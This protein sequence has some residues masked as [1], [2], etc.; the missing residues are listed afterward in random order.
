MIALERTIAVLLCAGESRRF[1][2]ADKLLHPLAGKPLVT[3]AAAMLAGLPFAQKIA[4]IRSDA[5]RLDAVLS[6][7]NFVIVRTQPGASQANS[8]RCGLDAALAQ[9]PEAILLALGDMPW[10]TAAHIAALA[11]AANDTRPAASCGDSWAGPPWLAPAQWVQAHVETLRPALLRD[12]AAVI[13]DDQVL[14]DVDRPE[15]LEAR[16]A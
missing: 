11:E 10:V 13:A 8:L 9:N 3:H 16:G 7:H 15:D 5:P 1:G 6:A 2:A 14:G 4:T 12:A